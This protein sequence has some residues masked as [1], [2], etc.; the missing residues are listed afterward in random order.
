MHFYH[1]IDTDPEVYYYTSG[2]LSGLHGTIRTEN[3]KG[4]TITRV[5]GDVSINCSKRL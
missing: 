5:N 3:L 4:E 1:L 2:T